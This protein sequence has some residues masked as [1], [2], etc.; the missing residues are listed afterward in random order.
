[1]EQNAKQLLS[2]ISEKIGTLT[3]K[4]ISRVSHAPN[5][6]EWRAYIS[7]K[8]P[9]WQDIAWR[10]KE[11]N[12]KGE[13]E[14]HLGFY[15]AKPSEALNNAIEK[16]EALA[17]GKVNHVVK[18]E[19]GIRL[20]WKAN[21]NDSVSLDTLYLTMAGLINDFLAAAFEGLTTSSL[22]KDQTSVS[23]PV[24]FY[25]GKIDESG[26]VIECCFEGDNPDII[27]MGSIDAN[28]SFLGKVITNYC[29]KYPTESVVL[30]N[31]SLWDTEDDAAQL[32]SKILEKDGSFQTNIKSLFDFLVNDD[33]EEYFILSQEIPDD[34]RLFCLFSGCS[35]NL[36]E[37]RKGDGSKLG[38]E[39]FF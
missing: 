32:W 16:S 19:N 39:V 27:L 37:V 35:I 31:A 13:A 30:D 28:G 33:S 21:L 36:N 4:E 3:D 18:N 8:E 7:Q 17:K 38:V 34:K 20:V 5:E 12:A 26:D 15:S 1:M 9:Y 10:V 11:P 14:V 2:R 29:D 25:A 24:G 22:K 6:N 23:Y